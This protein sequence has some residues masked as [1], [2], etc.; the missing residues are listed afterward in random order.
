MRLLPLSILM[1]VA[2]A[3]AGITPT[4]LT[5]APNTATPPSGPLVLEKVVLLSRHGVR[6]PTKPPE[7]LRRHSDQDWHPWPVAPGILT[8]HGADALGRLGAYLGQRY[9][10]AGLLAAAT[11]P[12]GR[13]PA[14]DEIFV[15]GDSGDQR[16]RAS[17]QALA[18]GLGS[19]LMAGDSGCAPLIAHSRPADSKDVLFDAASGGACPMD[20]QM[21]HQALLSASGG[22]LGRVPPTVAPALA[23]L[24]R[25]VAPR[26]CGGDH[27]AQTCFATGPS[28]VVDKGGEVKIDGPLA[29]GAMLAESLYLE[30][31][32]GFPAGE[33]AWG[34][35]GTSA[36]LAAA[37]AAILPVHDYQAD[38]T[39]RT[40]YLAS[41]NGAL[42]LRQ[43]A[44]ALQSA[45]PGD[46]TREA[47]IPAAARLVAI[48]GH[49]TNLSNVAGAL[50]LDWTLP[51]QPDKTAPDT[52]LAFETLRDVSTG[53][54]F[55]QV[56]LY[57]QT[58][59]D[60]RTAA[61]LTPAHP[62]G[63]LILPLPACGGTLCRL[64]DATRLL[65][66]AIAPECRS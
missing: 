55:V 10:A 65:Y 61:P 41:H 33:V 59:D 54:R 27:P 64:E 51:D 1:L 28:R 52:T 11:G 60:L 18:D 5:A 47:P 44:D 57:Y 50:G 48:M 32:Q 19:A 3:A 45:P 17:A 39:R 16:T 20:P 12:A 49:D 8:P 31:V 2:A 36:A 62:A 6:S 4:A 9:A 46:S 13:C 34:R 21:A 58:L 26:S 23:A 25:M 29:R 14:A 63:R 53:R 66:D 42:L 40:A 56:A 7:D 30:Y 15:W 22:D 37:L 38:L 43:I 24:A 35:G